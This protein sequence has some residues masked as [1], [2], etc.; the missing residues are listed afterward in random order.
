MC[1]GHIVWC[2]I[3]EPTK[4]I[5][6]YQLPLVYLGVALTLTT[7]TPWSYLPV[8]LNIRWSPSA[9]VVLGLSS[10]AL[11]C[12]PSV[13]LQWY[14]D[15][16]QPLQKS[17][18]N[19]F[20]TAKAFIASLLRNKKLQQITQIILITSNGTS[21][22]KKWSWMNATRRQCTFLNDYEPWRSCIWPLYKLSCKCSR[23]KRMDI[24]AR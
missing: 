2:T 23:L 5:F 6:D 1:V 11:F 9:A 19:P 10:I 14:P 20:R 22:W 21:S 8:I 3:E 16:K 17:Q 18:N 7:A 12:A 4:K 15:T 13:V 24:R